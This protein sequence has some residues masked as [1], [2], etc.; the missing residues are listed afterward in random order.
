MSPYA[1]DF[2]VRGGGGEGGAVA[3]LPAGDVAVGAKG[4]FSGWL[5]RIG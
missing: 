4:L 3:V 2:P 5:L 1:G